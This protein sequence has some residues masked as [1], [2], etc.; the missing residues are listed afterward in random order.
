MSEPDLTSG[1]NI[2]LFV[3]KLVNGEPKTNFYKLSKRDSDLVIQILK[4]GQLNTPQMQSF[5]AW[6][7]D[8]VKAGQARDFVIR[9]WLY[10]IRYP[11]TVL[12]DYRFS[13]TDLLDGK[14]HLPRKISEKAILEEV[15]RRPKEGKKIKVDKSG[16][17]ISKRELDE[18][19][20]FS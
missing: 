7:G 12:R 5:R 18:M 10:E 20:R 17:V 3:E 1:I 13:V 14:A 19:L 6:L 11:N 15:A 16:R 9:M 2:H 8:G 4:G